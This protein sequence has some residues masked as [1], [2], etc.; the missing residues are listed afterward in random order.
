M[1]KGVSY[2]KNLFIRKSFISLSNNSVDFLSFFLIRTSQCH[3]Q[4]SLGVELCELFQ[5]T[6]RATEN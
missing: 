3:S 1:I 5:N 2:D 4:R 6:I